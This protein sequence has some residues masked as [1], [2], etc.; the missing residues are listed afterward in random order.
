MAKHCCE[1]DTSQSQYVQIESE[2]E[3]QTK[4][5]YGI[6]CY[7]SFMRINTLPA[8]SFAFASTTPLAWSL[9]LSSI[10]FLDSSYMSK[11]ESALE[12]PETADSVSRFRSFLI[13][14]Q[15]S[16]LAPSRRASTGADKASFS[17]PC[18]YAI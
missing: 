12:S 18:K 7:L 8:S 2:N 4:L 13:A 1:P 14:G 3:K 6:S 10:L 5:T 17:F 11:P 16:L 15:V 9:R